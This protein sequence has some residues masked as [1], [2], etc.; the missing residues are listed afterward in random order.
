MSKLFSPLN[1]RELTFKNRIFVSPMCQYS[2]DDGMAT[3]WHLVHLGS[4]AVGGAAMVCVEATAVSPEGRISPGDSGIWSGEHARAFGPIAAFI[5]DQGSIPAIQLAHAGRKA[6]TDR[7]W[8][9][10]KPVDP[11]RGGWQ[12]IAPSPIPFAPGYPTP[13]EMTAPDI[14]AVA[15]QF[16]AAARRA[17]IAGFQVVELHMAHGYLMHEFLS[18]L[19]NHRHD[20]YGGSLAN[21]M[22]LPLRVAGAVREIWPARW[23]VFVRIS[24]SDWKEGGWDLSQ[25]IALSKEMAAIGIDLIDCSSGGTAHD[26]KVPSEPGYQVP[27]A[28]AIRREA[29]IATGAVGLI[30][31]AAQAE[32]II[33]GGKADAVLL[34]RQMLRDPYW[35]LHAA[36]EL[37]V[38]V[39]WPKQYERAKQ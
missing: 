34:A 7:P 14:E 16:S 17:L 6:S 32:E 22:R 37:G 19:S 11:S 33:A 36:K 8:F 18:P 31:S 39:P 35:P 13:R 1:L 38:D 5:R 20:E 25:S 23:P 30:T 24:A 27:F 4:R 12:P 28:E 21:R 10:G 26:A 3:D 2:S 29:K 9:G 15:G